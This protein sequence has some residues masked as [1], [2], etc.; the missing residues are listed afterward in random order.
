MNL[1]QKLKSVSEELTHK[2]KSQ[3]EKLYK[4]F[5][6]S[7]EVQNILKIA[8]QE[9][10]LKQGDIVYSSLSKSHHLFECFEIRFDKDVIYLS[11]NSFHIDDNFQKVKYKN[12][13]SLDHFEKVGVNKQ[14]LLPS[15]NQYTTKLWL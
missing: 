8:H 3:R 9:T 4:D 1:Q 11:T 5:F 10:G 6:E 2:L 14:S 13:F 7:E 15:K 12:A